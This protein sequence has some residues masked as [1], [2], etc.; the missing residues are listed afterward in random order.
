MKKILSILMIICIILLTGCSGKKLNE[1]EEIT[2]GDIYNSITAI[3]KNSNMKFVN[4][5]ENRNVLKV[6][7]YQ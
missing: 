6:Y 3:S 7:I 1:N 2:N 5:K 4:D